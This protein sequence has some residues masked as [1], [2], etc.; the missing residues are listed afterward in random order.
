MRPE[1]LDQRDFQRWYFAMHEDACK[2]ELDL[3]ADVH[4]GTV[5]CGGPPQSEAAV[6][7]LI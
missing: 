7:D 6:W 1:D 2:V 5:D 4:V 3:E